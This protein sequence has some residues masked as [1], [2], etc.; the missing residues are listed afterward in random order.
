[1]LV[2]EG[3]LYPGHAHAAEH[4]VWLREAA[5]C[6]GAGWGRLPVL[7]PRSGGGR[8]AELRGPPRSHLTPAVLGSLAP[9]AR[10]LA[11]AT[12]ALAPAAHSSRPWVWARV[13]GMLVAHLPGRF[14]GVCPDTA[15]ASSPPRKPANE[16]LT[17]AHNSMQATHLAWALRVATDTA[18]ASSPPR[19]PANEVL[20]HTIVHR[21]VAGVCQRPPPVP[22]RPC[23]V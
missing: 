5:S 17:H 18:P 23:G 3:Y 16:V 19:K 7:G 4:G 1:M 22:G 21:R 9:A 12:R 15:P 11:L 13:R 2:G 8:W 10:A 14:G 20:M 6:L